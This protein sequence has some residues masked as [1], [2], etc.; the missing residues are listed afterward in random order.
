MT[1]AEDVEEFVLCL[2]VDSHDERGHSSKLSLVNFICYFLVV[3]GSL[4]MPQGIDATTS[5]W[6]HNW[7][8]REGL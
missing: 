3:F 5:C 2:G 8:G 1:L 4:F 6:R 7:D